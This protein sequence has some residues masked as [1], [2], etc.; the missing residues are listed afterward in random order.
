MRSTL[1]LLS[2]LLFTG[3][4]I[5]PNPYDAMYLHEGGVW[6]RADRCCGRVG[7][8]FSPQ[9]S[10]VARRT[11]PADIPYTPLIPPKPLDA[12]EDLEELQPDAS[13]GRDGGVETRAPSEW[14][15]R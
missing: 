5:C 13:G 12:G 6:P 2:L 7:S 8:E 11:S 9:A 14:I 10:S 3:C 4:T 1:A 15:S